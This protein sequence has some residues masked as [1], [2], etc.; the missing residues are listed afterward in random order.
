MWPCQKDVYRGIKM[1]NRPTPRRSM[2]VN[3]EWIQ[4]CAS[5]SYN[6]DPT[7]EAIWKATRHKD[8]TKKTQIFLEV[9]T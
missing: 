3:I 2:G 9:P 7:P 1:A 8:L 5:E 6:V 4:V